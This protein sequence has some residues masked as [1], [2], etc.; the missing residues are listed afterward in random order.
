MIT[1]MMSKMM[2]MM[3]KAM[4][5]IPL[6]YHLPAHWGEAVCPLDPVVYLATGSL[7]SQVVHWSLVDIGCLGHN[8]ILCWKPL[9]INPVVL[10][11]PCSDTNKPIVKGFIVELR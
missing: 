11:L 6:Q 2:T 1:M 9:F 10:S 5:K 8:W 4:M 7:S 3:M